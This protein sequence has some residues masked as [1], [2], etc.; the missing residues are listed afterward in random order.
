MLGD[1]WGVSDMDAERWSGMALSGAGR[2][3][4]RMTGQGAGAPVADHVRTG[5]LGPASH[6]FADL[7]RL[8]ALWRKVPPGVAGSSEAEDGPNPGPALLGAEAAR[9]GLAVRC[10]HRSIADLD[11]SELPAVVMLRDGGSRLVLARKDAGHVTLC[12]PD[13]ERTVPVDMLAAA[14]ARTVF[15]ISPAEDAGAEAPSRS[16]IPPVARLLLGA[17]RDQRGVVLHLAL[18][19]A[20]ISLFGTALPLFSLA[21]YDRIIPHTAFETLFALAAGVTLALGLELALRH[22]R[23]KLFDAAGLSTSLALQGRVMTTLLFGPLRAVPRTAG[24]V[25]QPLQELEAL[26]Q[27]APQLFVALA[28]DLPFFVVILVLIGSLGGPV[29][30]APLIGTVALCLVHVAAHLLSHHSI[31]EQTGMVRRSIQAIVEAVGAQERVRPPAPA[32]MCCRGGSSRPTRRALPA[33]QAATGTALPRRRVPSSSSS[34]S[35]R[36]W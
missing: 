18:A 8:A 1:C 12:C 28:V 33:T 19:S 15:R 11:S 21:V 26:S 22:A 16:W 6:P 2:F 35:W 29:V 31:G 3:A 20:L 24:T 10:E 13:G 30:L 23:L 17:L 34:S 4:A 25:V 7:R 32:A 5:A 36:R 14:A 9:L 27:L